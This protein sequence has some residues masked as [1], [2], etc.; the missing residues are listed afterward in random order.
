MSFI[1][2]KNEIIYKNTQLLT[3]HNDLEHKNK[4]DLKQIDKLELNNKLLSNHLELHLKTI[5]EK[6]ADIEKL[7]ADLKN[8]KD[9]SMT[10]SKEF[11]LKVKITFL[12]YNLL[13]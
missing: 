5:H 4:S 12:N 3:Q 8:L 13:A 6:S 1:L 10:K 7:T 2:K 9:D 11:L